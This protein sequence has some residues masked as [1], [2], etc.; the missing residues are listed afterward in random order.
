MLS[1]PCTRH[2]PG[3][4]TVTRMPGEEEDAS[5]AAS[6]LARTVPLQERAGAGGGMAG[7]SSWTR[8]RPA[9]T[10]R[11]SASMAEKGER[12]GAG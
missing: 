1:T 6:P 12:G 8:P 2:L 5:A 9:M 11:A 3:Q 7:G 4:T 10:G